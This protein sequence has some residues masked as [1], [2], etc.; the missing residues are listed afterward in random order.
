MKFRVKSIVYAA[1]VASCWLTPQ[2]FTASAHA[3]GSDPMTDMARDRFQEG[4][5][6]YDA[7]DYEKARA[8]F[9]QAYALKKHP[10]VLLN[11]AQSELRSGREA[12]AAQH[13]EQ[14]LRENPSASATERQDAETGLEAARGKVAEITVTADPGAQVFVDGEPFGTAPLPAPIF[15]APGQHKLEA[16]KDAQSRVVDISAS[17]GLKLSP[18]LSFSAGQTGPVAGPVDSGAAPTQP[19]TEPAGNESQ[20]SVSTKTPREPFI[21]WAKRGP[22]SWIG[23]GLFGAGLIGGTVFAITSNVNYSTADEDRDRILA[24]NRR[25]GDPNQAPCLRANPMFSHFEA[26]CRQWQ[27]NVDAGDTHK[28]ISIISFVTAGVGAAVVVGG[29]FLTAKKLPAEE[30]S[31]AAKGSKSSFTAVASPVISQEFQGFSVG[32]TF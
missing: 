15:L 27:D 23:G 13:F 22:V 17:A 12:S 31:Q 32:G 30:Q 29:Y 24:E 9:L 3:Q 14:F 5:Q 7:K 21:D 25:V 20:F 8:A 10:S 6:Y 16:R 28:T 11:L 2:L 26:A 1:L 4:V 18:N 19:G